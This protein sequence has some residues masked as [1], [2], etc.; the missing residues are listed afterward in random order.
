MHHETKWMSA[1]KLINLKNWLNSSLSFIVFYFNSYHSA[2]SLDLSSIILFWKKSRKIM[3]ND[4]LNWIDMKLN[5]P[6]E[7]EGMGNV[8]LLSI[9]SDDICCYLICVAFEASS[10]IKFHHW[11]IVFWVVGIFIGIVLSL[12]LVHYMM[13]SI[14]E[15]HLTKILKNSR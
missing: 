12:F 4:L 3:I 1:Q 2:P 15:H 5:I 13:P 10:I 9:C 6:C 7:F 14:F 8:R 11:K